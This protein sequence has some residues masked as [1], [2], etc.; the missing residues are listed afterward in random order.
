M[1]IS[2]PLINYMHYKIN[3]KIEKLITFICFKNKK[4]IFIFTKCTYTLLLLL[5]NNSINS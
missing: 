4:C 5:K 2:S 3:I 1:Y